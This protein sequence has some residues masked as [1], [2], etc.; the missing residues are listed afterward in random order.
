MREIKWE[1]F[2]LIVVMSITTMI[3][4]VIVNIV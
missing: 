3:M 2:F 4:V 1:P